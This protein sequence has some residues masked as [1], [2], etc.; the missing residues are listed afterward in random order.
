ML[1][2]SCIVRLGQ[3]IECL[4]SCIIYGYSQLAAVPGS[5]SLHTTLRDTGEIHARFVDTLL[6]SAS[7]V[8]LLLIRTCLFLNSVVIFW[9][10]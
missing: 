2:Q 8:A 5:Y 10:G 3:D 7:V 1:V 4:F 9:I 6:G